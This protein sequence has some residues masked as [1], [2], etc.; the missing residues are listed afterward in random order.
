MRFLSNLYS[1]IFDQR[2]FMILGA[3][4]TLDI[5]RHFGEGNYFLM[6]VC[7]VLGPFALVR[8]WQAIGRGQLR[9]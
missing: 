1:F 2:V 6:L 3:V 4:M 9:G 8:G 5:L 7:L